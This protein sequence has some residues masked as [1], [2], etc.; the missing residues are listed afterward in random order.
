VTIPPLPANIVNAAATAAL[1]EYA[2]NL[3]NVLLTRSLLHSVLRRL[4]QARDVVRF[5]QIG[6]NDGVTDDPLRPYIARGKWQGLMIEPNP[7]A[8]ARLHS[9]YGDHPGIA[10]EQAAVTRRDGPVEL[11]LPAGKVP[12]KAFGDLIGTMAPAGG[13]ARSRPGGTTSVQVR[14]RRLH[15]ILD[16]H[17][18]TEVDVLQIDTEGYDFVVLQCIDFS[19]IRP[20][21]ISYEDRHF[22]PPMLRREAIELMRRNGYV[23]CP[24]LP[25]RDPVALD[26]AAFKALG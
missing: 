25:P 3:I 14:G 26:L 2:D 18:I 20:L 7:T 4:E 1:F 9:L 22:F 6:A 23:V 13:W 5:V 12:G 17:G 15:S 21:V 10:L 19:R 11:H 24:G 8:F 16:E